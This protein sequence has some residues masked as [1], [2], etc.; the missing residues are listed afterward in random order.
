MNSEKLSNKD[1]VGFN[2]A[3]HETVVERKGFLKVDLSI[4]LPTLNE[5]ESVPVTLSHLEKL[6]EAVDFELIVVDDDSSDGT[7]QKVLEISRNNSRVH[8]I[9]RVH[10]KGLSTAIMEGFMAGKIRLPHS[11]LPLFWL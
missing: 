4:I 7:W 6:L 8:L 3:L 11:A 1:I 9:R 2:K 5:V 10:R